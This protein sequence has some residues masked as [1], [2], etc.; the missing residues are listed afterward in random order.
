MALM[1]G[2]RYLASVSELD[3][4]VFIQGEKI[5][6]VTAHPISR[7][8]TWNRPEPVLSGFVGSEYKVSGV[9]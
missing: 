7:P 5:P 8:P 9:G 1:T 4:H 6:D 2:D 3:H